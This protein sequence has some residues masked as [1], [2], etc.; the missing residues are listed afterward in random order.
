MGAEKELKEELKAAGAEAAGA[1]AGAPKELKSPKP[2]FE[3]KSPKSPNSPPEAGG[4][5]GSFAVFCWV[6]LWAC[7]CCCLLGCDAAGALAPGLPI[8]GTESLPPWLL[9]LNCMPLTASAERE[10]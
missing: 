5:K 7:C 9:A 6:F 2:W 1:G 10:D 8:A 3:E 4:P